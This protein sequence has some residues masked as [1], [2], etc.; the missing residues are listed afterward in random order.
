MVRASP[1][2]ATSREGHRTGANP[3]RRTLTSA[4][5]A[6]AGKVLGMTM[7]GRAKPYGGHNREAMFRRPAGP[8]I[9]S[10]DVTLM[11]A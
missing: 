7:A 5:R 1:G 4:R 2:C 8:F 9:P 10:F 3:T 11:R 6:L